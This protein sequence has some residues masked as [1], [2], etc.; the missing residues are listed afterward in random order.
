[1]FGARR[2][3][4]I[5]KRCLTIGA[6]AE[7][8]DGATESTQQRCEHKAISVID[9]AR[10][11]RRS[12]ISDLVTGGEQ[13]DPQLAKDWQLAIAESGCQAEIRWRE[14]PTRGDSDRALGNI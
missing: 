2:S 9:H 8:A 10:R 12:R 1:M 7:V 3:Q 13:R 14:P 11:Q 6:N 4:G 5:G